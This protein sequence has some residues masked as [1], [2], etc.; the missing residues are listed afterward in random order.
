MGTSSARNR[1]M[2]TAK[3]DY[4]WFVDSDDM[5]ADEIASALRP[6]MID[7]SEVICFNHIDRTARGNFEKS[8]FNHIEHHSGKT[9]LE[10]A[11]PGYLWNKIFRR[12]VIGNTRFLEGTKNI[13]DFL[14]CIQVLKDVQTI[15]CL[16]YI[17]YIY[18]CTNPTS[19]L[20]NRDWKNLIKLSE[21]SMRVHFKLNEVI[22]SS[23][24][25]LR[26][27]LL[28]L[29]NISIAGHLHSLL[30]DY[31]RH[32]LSNAIEEYRNSGLYPILKT[33][34]KKANIFITVANIKWLLI[35]VASLYDLKRRNVTQDNI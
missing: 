6:H 31:N 33:S 27:I 35:L 17:G 1:G 7:D 18:N 22:H 10:K 8:T 16:P 23:S 15:T 20:R 25:T 11:A 29:L 2:E 4:I 26:P 12:D 19:T 30:I 28:N 9:L 32:I 21:D 14:F 34:N 5:I 3:C 13:E 24:P